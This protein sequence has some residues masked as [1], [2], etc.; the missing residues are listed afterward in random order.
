VF[1]SA[2][3]NAMQLQ[4]LTLMLKA[5]ESAYNKAHATWMHMTKNAA[6]FDENNYHWKMYLEK[7]RVVEQIANEITQ[8]HLKES[9]N[10]KEKATTVNLSNEDP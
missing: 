1:D 9:A 7:E 6:A 8:F 10:I 4:R 3:E 2:M 5:A